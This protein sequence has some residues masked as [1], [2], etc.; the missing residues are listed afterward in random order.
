MEGD[1]TEA[2]ID[3]MEALFNEVVKRLRNF[4]KRKKFR[5]CT[6]QQNQCE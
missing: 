4:I 2:N 1:E 3:E 6:A 5:Y